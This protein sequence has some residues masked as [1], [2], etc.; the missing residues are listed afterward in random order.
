MTSEPAVSPTVLVTGGTGFVASWCIAELLRR[1][2]AVRTT[3][4]DP[5]KEQDVRAAVARAAGSSDRLAFFV[6]D[7]T[8]DEGW[9]AATAGCDHVLHVASPLG[10]DDPR[11]AE[12]VIAPA[13]DGA[14]RVLA[15]ATGAGVRRVVLTSSTAAT[16]SRS[17]DVVGDETI[18][19]DTTDTTINAYRRSKALAERAAWDFMAGTSGPTT[20]T[21]ILPTAVFGPV[22]RDDGRGSVQLIQRLLDGRLPGL[23]RLGYCVVDVRD[24]ADLH[25]RAMTA[26]EAAGERFIATSDFLWFEEIAAALRARLGADASKVPTRRLPNAVVRL[27]ARFNAPLR[28]LTPGLGQR[29]LFTAAKAQR[30]LGF[31]PRPAVE[32]VVDCA[33]SLVAA[34]ERRTSTGRPPMSNVLGGVGPRP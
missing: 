29:R 24:L 3:V 8:R 28:E 32:T 2:Y 12:A 15:A 6:A 4:R 30:V 27:I 22:L 13:R 16:A 10:S 26:P 9:D 20:L 14:L 19:T 21:T 34:G 11:D 7:L 23:P 5:S 31:T 25:I 18:W 33:E 17:P 1:G